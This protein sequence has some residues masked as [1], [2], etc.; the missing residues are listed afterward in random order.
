MGCCPLHVARRLVIPTGLSVQAL[1]AISILPVPAANNAVFASPQALPALMRLMLWPTCSPSKNGSVPGSQEQRP[2]GME[3]IVSQAFSPK[4][5]HLRSNGHMPVHPARNSGQL[6]AQIKPAV[7]DM[8]EA[9]P[10][11]HPAA[12]KPAMKQAQSTDKPTKAPKQQR[13]RAA[14]LCKQYTLRFSVAAQHAAATLRASQKPLHGLHVHSAELI[15]AAM[16][17]GEGLAGGLSIADGA[18][19]LLSCMQSPVS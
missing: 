11:Q 5:S 12:A 6:A 1:H 18:A 14:W 9:Q 8:A 15:A 17:A 3:N 19:H 16:G 13:Q 10:D 4:P 2:L 7:S